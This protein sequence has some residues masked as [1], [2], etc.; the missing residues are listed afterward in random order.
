MFVSVTIGLF[1]EL[2]Q[3]EPILGQLQPRAYI[4]PPSGLPGPPD[5]GEVNGGMG[6]AGEAIPG[7][8]EKRGR[9]GQYQWSL[10]P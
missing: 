3:Y 6:K 7:C 10:A 2:A 9:R 1:P 5:G 4:L 8:G